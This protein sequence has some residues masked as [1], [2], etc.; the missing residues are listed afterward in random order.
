[1][2]DMTSGSDFYE[3]DEPVEKIIAAFERGEKGV[4]ARPRGRTVYLLIGKL[5]GGHFVPPTTHA[6]GHLVAR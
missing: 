1:M 2:T 3:E 5:S 4:T 6:S